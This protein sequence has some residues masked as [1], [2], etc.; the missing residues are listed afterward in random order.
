MTDANVNTERSNKTYLGDGLYAEPV[1]GHIR[2]TAEDGIQVLHE[3]FFEYENLT[4]L[5]RYAKRIEFLP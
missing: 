5:I 3:V 4:A 2:V 1:N